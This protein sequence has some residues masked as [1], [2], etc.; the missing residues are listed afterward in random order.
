MIDGIM[1]NTAA[2]MEARCGSWSASRAP[3]LMGR[4][5]KG[6]P[7]AGYHDLIGEVAAERLTNRASTHFVT[8]AMQRGLDLE[9]EAAEAYAFDRDV[10]LGPSMLVRH[11]KFER[12]CATPDRFLGDD[13]LLEIKC[14]SVQLKHLDTLRGGKKSIVNEYRDQCLWQLWCT[15]R[16]YCDLASY[17]PEFPPRLRLAVVRIERDEKRF[18]EFA[19]AIEQA[20]RDVAAI[21]EQLEEITLGQMP[22]GVAA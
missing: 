20:E 16:Q 6:E 15:G 9:P 18:D 12:V 3:T 5:A 17:F 13:G 11:P 4:T 2:W 10:V 14:L 19:A 8:S 21:L 1:P 22:E 7:T